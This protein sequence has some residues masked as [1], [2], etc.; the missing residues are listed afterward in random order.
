MYVSDGNLR[1][2][3]PTFSLPEIRCCE[4]ATELCKEFC[5]AKKTS[6]RFRASRMTKA[7]N[8]IDSQCKFFTDDMITLLKRRKSKYVRI[9]E[10]GDFYSQEYL[11]KWIKICKEIPDKKFLVYTQMYGLD[12]SNKPNNMILYWSVWPDT[13]KSKIPKGLKAYVKDSG[14]GKIPDYEI[15]KNIKE[16]KKGKDNTLTCD[17]CL[18][19]YEGKG[20]VKFKL[21]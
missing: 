15:P 21:H 4:G 11:D 2:K 12:W 3:I 17:K 5:Y 18:Y 20:D 1:M 8:Y 9:H 19:C 6:Y 10:A 16:C 7:K 14:N 13:D